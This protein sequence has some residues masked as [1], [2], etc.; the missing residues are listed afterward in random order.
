MDPAVNTYLRGMQATSSP[1]VLPQLALEVMVNPPTPGDCSYETY[2]QV[3]AY[4]HTVTKMHY[5]KN[6]KNSKTG[7]QILFIY[8]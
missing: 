6:S 8:Y 5:I 2:K 1:P 3:G 7:D 4:I